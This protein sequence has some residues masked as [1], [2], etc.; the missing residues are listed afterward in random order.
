MFGQEYQCYYGEGNHYWGRNNDGIIHN[1]NNKVNYY[2][3]YATHNNGISECNK[4]IFVLDENSVIDIPR[5]LG[6]EA[7]NQIKKDDYI[8]GT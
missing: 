8:E 7:N 5:M 3:I 2:C 6:I 1:K 4:W